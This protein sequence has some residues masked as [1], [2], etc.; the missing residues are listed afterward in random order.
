MKYILAKK[1]VFVHFLFF[2]GSFFPANTLFNQFSTENKS[3]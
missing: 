1:S 3:K 2:P